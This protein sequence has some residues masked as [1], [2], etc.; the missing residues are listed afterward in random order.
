M[1]NQQNLPGP[2]DKICE[3]HPVGTASLWSDPSGLPISRYGAG[4]RSQPCVTEALSMT[5]DAH[6]TSS[7]RKQAK[8]A[9]NSYA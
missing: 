9:H 6:Q 1:I 8:H 7:C 4:H 5:S 3:H 2:A